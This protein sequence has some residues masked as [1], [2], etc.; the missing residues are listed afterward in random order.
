[1]LEALRSAWAEVGRGSPAPGAEPLPVRAF[2]AGI[3]ATALAWR[4]LLSF[5]GLPYLHFWDEPFVVSRALNML[6]TGALDPDFFVYVSL[7]IYMSLLVQIFHY[8]WLM[9]RP[10]TAPAF[11]S[12]IDQIVT[13]SDT[14]WLWEISPS[15]PATLTGASI[16]L[17]ATAAVASWLPA[18]RAS[19]TD[20]VEVLRAD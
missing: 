13:Y 18:Y 1:M 17:L 9:S 14:G 4:M 15:D 16:I 5:R 12:H 6:K 3:L 20:P 11:L 7:P 8:F 10:E 19:R 2:L